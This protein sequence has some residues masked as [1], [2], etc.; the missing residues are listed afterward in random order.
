M[1]RWAV[2][3]LSLV[4]L[5]GCGPKYPNCDKDKDCDK[6]K[7]GEVCLKGKCVKCKDDAG[8]PKG[9]SC[10]GGSCEPIEGYCEAKTDC[11]PGEL[12]KDNQCSPGCDVSSDCPKGQ[13]C[14]DKQCLDENKCQTDADCVTGQ[15]CVDNR[16][17]TKS[18][19]PGPAASCSLST[20]FFEYNSDTIQGDNSRLL[21][22]NAECANR[23]DNSSR[24]LVI[25]G[26]T[27]P[28][29]TEEYNLSLGERRALV[30]KDYLSR[31]GVDPARIRTFS[32]GAEYAVGADEGGWSKDRR[33]EIEFE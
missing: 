6:K 18:D 4:A 9:Q 16:C 15:S 32:N 24:R 23:P 7:K 22:A 3:V 13:K 1:R 12:C 2:L 17:V 20:V 28:R 5:A 11:G 19:K 14:Q 31:L 26:Y 33:A 30:V 27:D 10:D 29:G 25:K 21:E 8:C